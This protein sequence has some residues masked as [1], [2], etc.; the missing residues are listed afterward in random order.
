MPPASPAIRAF[1]LAACAVLTS[2]AIAGCGV[3]LDSDPTATAAPTEVTFGPDDVAVGELLNRS[4]DA[5]DSVEGWSSESRTEQVD[6]SGSGGG[7][8]I[9]IEEVLLPATRRVLSTTE[10]TVVSEEMVVGGQIYLRGT[11]V[12]AAIDPDI[13][14]DTWITFSPDAVPP[15]LPLAQRV[16]YLMAAPEFPFTDVTTETR[17]LP[18]S[19]SG[20]IDIDG[21][22]CAVYEFVTAGDVA[23]GI[24]YRIAFDTDWLP[25]QLTLEGG[26]IVETT[27]WSFDASAIEI[28]AP[29]DAMRVDTFPE[30]P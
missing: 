7:S 9:T 21:R 22:A 12:P 5:W 23:I 19:P 8:T 1:R 27:T 4:Q 20:D 18:A 15:D 29:Q 10:E 30:N 6:A 26:G 3:D 16:Q 28:A 2:V 13:A 14:A 17:S 25:C 11:L 24:T